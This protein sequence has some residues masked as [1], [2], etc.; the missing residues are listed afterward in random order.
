MAISQTNFSPEHMFVTVLWNQNQ[1][2]IFLKLMRNFR[3]YITLLWSLTALFQDM[4]ESYVFCKSFEAFSK[5]FS[6]WFWVVHASA[7]QL[8]PHVMC[9]FCPSS[10]LPYPAGTKI[11][12]VHQ[13]LDTVLKCFQNQISIVYALKQYNHCF[14]CATMQVLNVFTSEVSHPAPSPMCSVS[15]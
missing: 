13:R 11:N 4:S 5:G 12:L 6:D 10:I 14:D 15:C 1:R 2:S 9:C 7:L 8:D 3:N